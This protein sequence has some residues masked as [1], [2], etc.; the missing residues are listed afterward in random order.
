MKRLLLL[1]HLYLGL[2]AALFLIGISLSGA[3][4]AFEPELNHFFHPHLTT[5]EPVAG[6][7]DWDRTRA[8]V[9]SHAPGWKVI[10]F[11][12]PATPSE[13]TYLRLRS[14]STHRIR[15]V[16]VNQYTG[17][18]LGSTE[19]GSNWII[20]VHDL[21]VNLLSGKIGNALVTAATTLLGVLALS[22]IVLWW[23]VRIFKPRPGRSA[24]G[25]NRDL[26]TSLGF[27]SFLAM[28]LFSVTGLAL[29]YQTGKLLTLLKTNT[30]GSTLAGHG[31]SINGMLLTAQQ[32]L[33]GTTVPRLLLPEKPGDPVFLYQRFPEDKTP[34]GRSYTTLDPRTGAV[35]SIGSSR[36]APLLQTALVQWA[37]E[38]HT[39]TLLGLPTRILAVLLSLFLTV[40]A[41]TGPFIWINRQRAR[42][43]GR[44]AL[45][46]HRRA[47]AGS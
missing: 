5:I 42:A 1:T 21:H 44:R 46:E 34:A 17:Q 20:K 23:P 15:H 24:S 2:I 38:I 16:Y 40:L 27:W 33:P 31:T 19:D 25:V 37:R 47:T 28:L 32:A 10:R 9:E 43:R 8:L 41:V 7:V 39:G 13:S 30:A 3:V 14:T 4:I 36:S 12:F 26:H 11:Y 35:L 18:I 45:L 6:P 29:H 22:G